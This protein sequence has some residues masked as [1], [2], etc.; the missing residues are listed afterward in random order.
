MQSGV[1]TVGVN[2]S[3]WSSH[4]G[5]LPFVFGMVNGACSEILSSPAALAFA[6]W[7]VMVDQTVQPPTSFSSQS[8]FVLHETAAG[9]AV[10][11]GPWES[12]DI[13]FTR[14]EECLF[15]STAGVW[16]SFMQ[17]GVPTFPE[18]GPACAN[19]T[20]PPSWYTSEE[21]DFLFPAG[22]LH[23]LSAPCVIYYLACAVPFVGRQWRVVVTRVWVSSLARV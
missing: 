8:L 22:Y 12:I 4:S 23:T 13:P 16:A 17:T 7:G 21:F 18:N 14:A 9:S 6:T 20:T 19:V 1:L 10:F 11:P 5:E 2:A 3:N 15:R